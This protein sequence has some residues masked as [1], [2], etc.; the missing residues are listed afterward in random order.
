MGD[1][2]ESDARVDLTIGTGSETGE[3]ISAHGL[4]DGSHWSV[5]ANLSELGDVS[6]K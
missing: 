3:T 5:S 6:L 2:D 4:C 1:C